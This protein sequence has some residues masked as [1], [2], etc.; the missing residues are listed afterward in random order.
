MKISTRGFCRQ[1]LVP[2][3]GES[4][5][6][7]E[8]NHN[9]FD[10]IMSSSERSPSTPSNQAMRQ[11]RYSITNAAAC[12]AR[13]Q[14]LKT[15]RECQNLLKISYAG[16]LWNPSAVSREL[17]SIPKKNGSSFA[18]GVFLFAYQRE[19]WKTHG[20]RSR[21]LFVFIHFHDIAGTPTWEI[22][23]KRNC[24][25]SDENVGALVILH[26]SMEVYKASFTS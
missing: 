17:L 21:K 11:N 14:P 26:V 5:S 16:V 15:W 7:R 8:F 19:A 6:T 4:A 24:S 1:G 18:R 13:R 23:L 2:A 9:L 3:S 20:K 25:L 10:R 22:P 12:V